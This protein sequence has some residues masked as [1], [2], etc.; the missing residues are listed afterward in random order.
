MYKM[1]KNFRLVITLN[2]NTDKF[3][4]KREELPD[5]LSRDLIQCYLILLKEMS[6]KISQKG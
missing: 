6:L 5:G 2:P 3:E 4:S 1:H